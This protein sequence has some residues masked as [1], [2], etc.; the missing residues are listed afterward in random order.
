MKVRSGCVIGNTFLQLVYFY[1]NSVF[2]YICLFFACAFVFLIPVWYSINIFEL[3][4]RK[5]VI[6]KSIDE[7]GENL[8]GSRAC[9]TAIILEK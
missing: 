4:R 9:H 8:L 1:S 3:L 5:T 6:C 2:I 7:L